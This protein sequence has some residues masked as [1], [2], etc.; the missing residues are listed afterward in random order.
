MRRM[1]LAGASV[2]CLAAGAHVAN[3]TEIQP[4]LVVVQHTEASPEVV[5]SQLNATLLSV[6]K[7][8]KTLGFNGRYARLEPVL[9]QVY[10][11]PLM[12][13]LASGAAWT[14]ATPDQQKKLV[15][16]FSHF[17]ISNYA[18]RFDGYSGERF[19]VVG[20]KAAN[21]GGDIVE[22][23]LVT[24]GGD[25]PVTLNY[26]MRQTPSWRVI[27]VFLDGT[28]SELA[29]RRAEFSAVIRDGGV[30]A[31]LRLLDEKSKMMEAGITR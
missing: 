25:K 11:F 18:S 21:G 22:T 24:T 19:E 23:R 27:D 9:K 12:T 4:A 17:S 20:K 10:D 28:I 6:M 14:K 7:D 26:L 31:L 3:A 8:A 5:V 30:E 13:R 2:I 15:D 29:S 16:A 1:F